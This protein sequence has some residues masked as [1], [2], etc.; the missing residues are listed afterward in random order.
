M[1]VCN[2]THKQ[3][4]VTI[5]KMYMV[6]TYVTPISSLTIAKMYVVYCLYKVGKTIYL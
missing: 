4:L 2:N 6:W 1:D 3:A 5:A